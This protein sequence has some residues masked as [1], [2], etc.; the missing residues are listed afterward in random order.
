MSWMYC[1]C[2]TFVAGRVNDD[3]IGGG[4]L[5]TGDRSLRMAVKGSV[6]IIFGK[7][8]L[9]S[10]RDTLATTSLVSK[11]SLRE[12]SWSYRELPADRDSYMAAN[13]ARD[14]IRKY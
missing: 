5:A 12:K 7:T 1:K 8:R 9:D 13:A 10:Y 3:S 2:R 6:Y 14:R 4:F 11:H